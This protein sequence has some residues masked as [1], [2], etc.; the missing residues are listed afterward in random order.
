MQSE[1]HFESNRDHL[2][3][4]LKYAIKSIELCRAETTAKDTTPGGDAQ[5]DGKKRTLA[6][7]HYLAASILSGL[8]RHEEAAKHLSDAATKAEGWPGLEAQILRARSVCLEHFKDASKGTKDQGLA[9]V[10]LSAVLNTQVASLL[11]PREIQEAVTKAFSADPSLAVGAKSISWPTKDTSS[12]PIEF[13]VTFPGMTQATSGDDV[14]AI[15]AIKSRLCFPVTVASGKLQTTVGDVPLVL[16]DPIVLEPNRMQT[17]HAN[18]PLPFKMEPYEQ[19][20]AGGK[21]AEKKLKPKTAG[22]T[23]AAGACYTLS[24]NA[25]AAAGDDVKAGK[26]YLGGTP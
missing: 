16:P 2:D 25:S 11:S 22:M 5:S 6:R 23:R 14:P 18:I 4:A 3:V 15:V 1:Y 19:H 26:A 20:K 21:A 8:G 7:L 13:I 12:P 17:L 10:H 24:S 9:D